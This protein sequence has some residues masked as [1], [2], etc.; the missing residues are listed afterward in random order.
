MNVVWSNL[1]RENAGSFQREGDLYEFGPQLYDLAECADVTC[2]SD[3]VEI[4]YSLRGTAETDGGVFLIEG[5]SPGFDLAL[6]GWRANRS[7][8]EQ[9]WLVTSEAD[10]CI[11]D[12]E[13]MYRFAS[14]RG[15]AE[16][17]A[18]AVD[19]PALP[20]NRPDGAK[21]LDVF[22]THGFRVS[23]DDSHAWG[24]EVFKRLWQSGS[25]VNF[26]MLTWRGDYGMI[27][28]GLYYQHNAW[29]AQ[30]TG[31][32][33]KRYVEAAQPVAAKRILMTQSLGNMVAC[34]ALRE[35]LQVGQYYMF[36]A[37]IPSEAIDE[38]LRAETQEDEAFAKY[39]PYTWHDYTNACW[40][41]NWHRLFEQNPDD[42]RGKMGWPNRFQ[43]ALIN[44]TEVLNYY[45]SGDDVFKELATVPSRLDGVTESTEMYCWQKQE[46]LKGAAVVAGTAYGGWGFHEWVGGFNPDNYVPT[47]AHYTVEQA[48]AMVADGS[49]T[50]NPVF[51]RG[52]APMFDRNASQDDQW[53]ALAKYVPALSS[54]VGGRAV[55]I[56]EIDFNINMNLTDEESGIPR[57][58]GWGRP[59]VDDKTDWHHS[60]MKDMAYFYVYK[61]YE[62]LI[63]KGNLK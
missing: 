17:P 2:I 26:H 18:L 13:D 25:N 10:I 28:S 54:P 57:P 35:G 53:L 8:N 58:N 42:S 27:D 21:D 39:V 1:G 22:F 49:V 12:V 40:A 61:L 14:L 19:V 24:S 29:L 36:D 48:T 46:T 5:W 56:E 50:N 44:A 60:D 4:P 30:R 34:E 20:P 51:N 16:D 63:Q 55:Q 38:T 9:E 59:V 32:A 52:F 47:N 41:S 62:Q 23:E 7:Q 15:A 33:L 37:A 3:G 43:D 6:E 31:G 45:S 11:T